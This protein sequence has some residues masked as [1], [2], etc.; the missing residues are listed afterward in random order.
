MTAPAD[1]PPTSYESS[2]V[3]STLQERSRPYFRSNS[4]T[5]LAAA[6]SY[7]VHDLQQCLQ[8][9]IQL[10][11]AHRRKERECESALTLIASTLTHHSSV[12]WDSDTFFEVLST[13]E[14][15]EF[16]GRICTYISE[17]RL[18]ESDEERSRGDADFRRARRQ[19]QKSRKTQTCTL[20]S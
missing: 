11:G 8:C 3:P 19:F 6:A 15:H 18:R 4:Q 14:D 12:A 13:D 1:I 5:D 9:M 10:K 7:T 2:P 16:V 20:S 17:L